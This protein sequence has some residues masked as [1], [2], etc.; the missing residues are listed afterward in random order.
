MMQLLLSNLIYALKNGAT[1]LHLAAF[2]TSDVVNAL[3]SSGADIHARNK[4]SAVRILIPDYHQH[5]HGDNYLEL[6]A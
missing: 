2:N 1:P 3:I 4:V 6:P 5:L